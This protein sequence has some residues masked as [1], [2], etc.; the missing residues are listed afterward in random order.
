MSPDTAVEVEEMEEDSPIIRAIRNN[1]L[2]GALWERTFWHPDDDFIYAKAKPKNLTPKDDE[3]FKNYFD[4]IRSTHPD[5][6]IT[7][8]WHTHGDKHY[9]HNLFITL[10]KQGYQELKDK[11]VLY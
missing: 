10:H 11:G 9:E 1:D 8:T 4:L 6:Y 2:E 5:G 3:E 7:Y